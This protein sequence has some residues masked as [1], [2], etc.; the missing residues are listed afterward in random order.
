M[1]TRSHFRQSGPVYGTAVGCG[2]RVAVLPE[3]ILRCAVGRFVTR[4]PL[5][6]SSR[7]WNLYEIVGSNPPNWTDP[8]GLLPFAGGGDSWLYDT[9]PKRSDD[10]CC[11][12]AQNQGIVEPITFGGM[13]CCDGR[14][15]ACSW[16]PN[17][18]PGQSIVGDCII[19]HEREHFDVAEPC[20]GGPLSCI[21][22]E[23]GTTGRK[24]ECAAYKNEVGC[25]R[26][27]RE[28][29]NG[30]QACLKVVDDRINH[31]EEYVVSDWGWNCEELWSND[32][33]D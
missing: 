25:L 29:C 4:D 16:W 27:K 1:K 18:T 13:V 33:E 23:D 12:D 8:T 9:C 20:S 10:E 5:N 31:L 3:S 26:S 6:Y 14:L 32:P 2:D 7:Q 21:R 15:V 24:E 17:M 22:F 28:N 19:E 11:K 30:D